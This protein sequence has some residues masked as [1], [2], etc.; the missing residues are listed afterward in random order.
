VGLGAAGTNAVPN[1][2][3]G[4]YVLGGA[5]NNLIGGTNAGE[6]NIVSGNVSEGIYI[7]DP[8]T[9]N[10]VVLGNRIG[11]DVSGTNSV[12]N[13]FTGVGIWNGAQNNFIGGTNAGAGNLISGNG[14]NGVSLGDTNTSGNLVRGNFIGT[15][16]DGLSPLNNFSIGV[17]IVNGA[18]GNIVGG[19]TPATRNLISGNGGNGVLI[20]DPGTSGNEVLGNYIGVNI[21]GTGSLPNGQS[22]VVIQSGAFANIIGTPDPVTRNILSGNGA[23][24][25]WISDSGTI[26]NLVQGNYIGVAVDGVTAVSNL[27]EGVV[28]LNGAQANV[29]GFDITGAGAGNIIANSGLEGVA[30]YDSGSTSNTIRGNAIFNNSRLGINLAGGTE[31]AFGVTANDLQDPDTGPNDLQNF[32]VITSASVVGGATSVAGTLNSTPS[33]G[34]IIDVYRNSAADPSGCGEG[35]VYLGSVPLTT[36]AAGNGN[37]SFS[38]NGSFAG[39]FIATTAT[40][41]ATGDTSE[42]SASVVATNGVAPASGSIIVGPFA[43]TNS[44]F[45]F[46][47]AVQ[48]NVSYRIQATTNLA[49]SNLWV[50]LTNFTPTVSPAPFADRG[51]SNFVRRFYRVVSP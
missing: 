29:I 46:N 2:F 12:P 9:T 26:G 33:R 43:R 40:D 19:N 47:I 13:G 5:H 10:N 15:T 37:F 41:V 25:I 4:I 1:S 48:P 44:V 34:F 28:I 31:D 3:A 30:I 23:R 50:D 32:P 35:Q 36:D 42:F 6:G 22:G 49:A 17:F 8:G 11:T 24:G 27:W 18:S 14:G 21:N 16:P 39:Q 45:G 38:T 7:A 51:A 20:S